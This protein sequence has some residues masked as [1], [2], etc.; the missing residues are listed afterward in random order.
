MSR[1][2]IRSTRDGSTPVV[3]TRDADEIAR[4]LAE[5]G[6][7]FARWTPATRPP[8]NGARLSKDEI[9]AS[10]APGVAALAERGYATVDVISVTPT[11]DPQ[12]PERARS[13]R[14][15]FRDEHTH[16]ED[17]VRFF[18]W[19]RGLFYLRLDEDV[20]HLVLCEAG[21]LLSVPAGTR[22]WFDM[23]SE[24]RFSAI[25][26]FTNPEGWVGKFTDDPIARRFPSLDEL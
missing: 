11:P 24:P 13:M 22:H 3:D 14:E 20:V 16:A 23:G 4:R 8:S 15:K 9:L 10:Y 19:G 25:R 1:L 2:V 5:R 17:E 6:V 21:D 26:F 7:E 18:A 12:W